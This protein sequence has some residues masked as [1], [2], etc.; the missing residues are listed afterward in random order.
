MVVEDVE[1]KLWRDDFEKLTSLLRGNFDEILYPAIFYDINSEKKCQNQP[2][3]R[4]LL[5]P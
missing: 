1:K 4:T 3:R 2:I 5:A